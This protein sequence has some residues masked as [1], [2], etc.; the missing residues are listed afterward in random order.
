MKVVRKEAVLEVEKTVDVLVVGGGPAGVGAAVSAARN[1]AKVLLLEKRAFLG[2]NITA[3]YVE[4]CNYF[5][6]PPFHSEGI[7]AVSYTHL[8]SFSLRRDVLS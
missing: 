1:G 3:C 6:K 8:A 5:V 7:Y 2:G 4:N